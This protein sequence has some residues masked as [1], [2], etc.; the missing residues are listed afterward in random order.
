[1]FDPKVKIDFTR[2]GAFFTCLHCNA[3]FREGTR[4]HLIKHPTHSGIIREKPLICPF[5][6]KE[7]R[8]PFYAVT[9][10]AA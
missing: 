3:R 7:F 1:M 6:G 2:H 8:N 10:E 5:A 4:N 9:L